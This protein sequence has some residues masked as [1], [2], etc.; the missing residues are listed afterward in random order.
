MR[1]ALTPAGVPVWGSE[2]GRGKED[3]PTGGPVYTAGDQAGATG[4]PEGW[5]QAHQR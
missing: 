3:H 2:P 1:G 4:V 5:E